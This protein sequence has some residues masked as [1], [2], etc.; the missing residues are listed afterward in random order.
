MVWNCYIV[1]S[2]DNEKLQS[3]SA[4]Y[5]RVNHFVAMKPLWSTN[6]LGA[7]NVWEAMGRPRNPK[8][9]S[10]ARTL[11]NTRRKVDDKANLVKFKVMNLGRANLN[12]QRN[13]ILH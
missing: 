8:E 3:I 4:Y 10:P 9:P 13:N 12:M 1:W 7:R 6:I 5:N 2:D 11:T